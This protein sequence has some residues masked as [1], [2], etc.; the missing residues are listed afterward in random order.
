MIQDILAAFGLE[1]ARAELFGNGLIN[2]TWKVATSHERYIL[3]RVEDKIFKHP[4]DI[5]FNTR[6]LARY[7]AKNYPDYFFVAPIYSTAGHDLLH[8]PGK[9]YYRLF[10][11]VNGSHAIDIVSTAEQ[12]YE[13]SA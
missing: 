9:G 3:Q 1:N 10:F 7:V 4:E 2:R 11:F 13:A 8:V 6:L 5:A 12:A